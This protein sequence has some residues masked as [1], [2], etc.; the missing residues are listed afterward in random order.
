VDNDAERVWLRK[1]VSVVTD[2]NW[3]VNAACRDHPYIRTEQFFLDPPRRPSRLPKQT[4]LLYEQARQVCLDEC[5]VRRECLNEAMNAERGYAG[6][7]RY[8]IFG[9]LDPFQ[10]A[11]LARQR[12]SILDEAVN[13][14]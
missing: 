11:S 4:N 7:S 6:S 13:N 9:G 1:P 14:E 5:E 3:V 12:I 8:G 2:R 10:R